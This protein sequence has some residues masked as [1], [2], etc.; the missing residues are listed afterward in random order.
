MILI[1]LEDQHLWCFT[2]TFPGVGHSTKCCGLGE[3]MM[4]YSGFKM[5]VWSFIIIPPCYR[6]IMALWCICTKGSF[7]FTFNNIRNKYVFNN[8]R[9]WWRF[10]VWLFV[11]GCISF[12]HIAHKLFD[13]LIQGLEHGVVFVLVV[14]GTRLAAVSDICRSTPQNGCH[15]PSTFSSVTSMKFYYQSYII[16]ISFTFRSNRRF[17]FLWKNDN[18][19]G[20]LLIFRNL[21]IGE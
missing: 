8:L 12:P 18:S 3:F 9:S 16:N 11:S 5:S 7:F 14:K 1:T 19:C 21:W 6:W 4:D 10:F 17:A 13:L 15:F 2:L 20:H